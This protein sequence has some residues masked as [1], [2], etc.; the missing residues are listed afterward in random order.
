[1]EG[2]VKSSTAVR[3]TFI[4][5]DEAR[6]ESLKEQLSKLKSDTDA[7]DQIEDIKWI[8]DDCEAT[9]L[10]NLQLSKTSNH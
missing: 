3:F 8:N 7:A 2:N 6:F 1:M 4:E 5:K 10:A 9:I